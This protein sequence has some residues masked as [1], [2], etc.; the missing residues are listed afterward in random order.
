MSYI[1]EAITAQWG[2]KCKDFDPECF[3]CKAWE[4]YY[5]LVEKASQI[6]KP[7]PVSGLETLDPKGP[8]KEVQEFYQSLFD[9]ESENQQLVMKIQHSTRL[10]KAAV[11]KIWKEQ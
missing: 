10:H 1:A 5:D 3:T 7:M 6:D 8:S 11:Y 9:A 2:E 4:E